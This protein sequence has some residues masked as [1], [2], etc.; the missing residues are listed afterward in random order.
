MSVLHELTM[1]ELA[2]VGLAKAGVGMTGVTANSDTAA[3]AK[4]VCFMGFS[5]MTSKID[6]HDA[7]IFTDRALGVLCKCGTGQWQEANFF[8]IC[9][10]QRRGRMR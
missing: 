7:L 8:L 2:L 4:I 1:P 10:N 9:A 6:N 3:N 5:P